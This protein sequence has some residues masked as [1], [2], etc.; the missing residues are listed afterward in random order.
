MNKSQIV[1]MVTMVRGM[2]CRMNLAVSGP[3]LTVSSTNAITKLVLGLTCAHDTILANS[4]IR[5]T[6]T[7]KGQL[8]TDGSAGPH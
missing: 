4:L 3:D 8:H 7:Q 2:N 5:L 6:A 1:S